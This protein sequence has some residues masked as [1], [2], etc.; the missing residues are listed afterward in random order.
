MGRRCWTGV[1]RPV[2]D[3]V[4]RRERNAPPAEWWRKWNM[5]TAGQAWAREKADEE[6][7]AQRLLRAMLER[8]EDED[9]K[10]RRLARALGI[11]LGGD[12]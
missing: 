1:R 6:W 7:C 10:A 8:D 12:R 2:E 5:G 3:A 4:I 11:N 9:E